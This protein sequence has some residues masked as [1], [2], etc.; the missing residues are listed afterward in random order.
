MWMKESTVVG[1]YVVGQFLISCISK[2]V[3][4]FDVST[5]L[6]FTRAPAWNSLPLPFQRLYNS[7]LRVTAILRTFQN[8]IVESSPLMCRFFTYPDFVCLCLSQVGVI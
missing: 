4:P 1:N 6:R 2:A 8:C 7:T 5:V 3:S